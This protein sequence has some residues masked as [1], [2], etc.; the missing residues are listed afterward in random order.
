V[1][2]LEGNGGVRWL[3]RASRMRGMRVRR[4]ERTVVCRP[5]KII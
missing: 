5:K 4:I 2:T 3:L 1:A